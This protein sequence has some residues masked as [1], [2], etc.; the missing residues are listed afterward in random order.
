MASEGDR[1]PQVPLI[2]SLSQL[3]DSQTISLSA[4][5]SEDKTYCIT[6]HADVHALA[7]SIHQLGLIH[8]PVLKQHHSEYVI[9][10]GF[11]RIAA[12][13]QI[14]WSKISAGVLRSDVNNETCALYAIAD[15]SL[16]RPLNLV[17]ISRSL[18]LLSEY[19]KDQTQQLKY[20]SQLGLPDH[21]DH[22]KKIEKICQ[23]PKPIQDAMLCGTISLPVAL[24]LLKFE[25]DIGIDLVKLFDQLKIGI[26]KQRELILLFNE[27]ALREK[28]PLRRL[29]N[30]ESIG[31]I[32]DNPE[33]D[34]VQKSRR[35]KHYLSQ[36][37][38]PAIFNTKK[39]F[40]NLVKSLEL[41]DTMRLIPP[42]DFEGPTYT[43]T[44]R[45]KTHSELAELQSKLDN[46]VR[47]PDLKD[48]LM[49]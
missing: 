9:V 1:R 37:R 18:S 43:L 3:I 49:E 21:R 4:I 5:N 47:N 20:A 44:L 41:G 36:R 17:E 26:N 8:P 6:T 7:A 38:F 33:L 14:G 10:S 11:R 42:K 34:R 22:I 16:Q 40:E 12:C 19:V 30:E 39:K 27:I 32:L 23:L 45:F 46:I 13:R 24:D 48:Y 25:T 29:L 15:N 35:M 2:R 31:Q 28:I